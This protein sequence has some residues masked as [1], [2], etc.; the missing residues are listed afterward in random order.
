MIEAYD[1]LVRD[2]LST[3][4]RDIPGRARIVK[5]KIIRNVAAEISLARINLIRNSE[6]LADGPSDDERLSDHN[7]ADSHVRSKDVRGSQGATSDKHAFLKLSL[8]QNQRSEKIDRA[9]HYGHDALAANDVVSVLQQ[10]RDKGGP[11][12]AGLHSL[13]TIKDQGAVPTKVV[14]ILS[15]WSPGSDP[16]TYD[17]QRVMQ[18]QENEKSRVGNK[19]TTYRRGTRNRISRSQD[20]SMFIP[21]SLAVPV[22]RQWGSQPQEE[23]PKAKLQSS[24]V[25]EEDLPMT[26]VERGVF[27]GREAGKKSLLKA[28]KKKRAAGF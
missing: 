16:T 26:Q 15:H 7:E 23:L 4:P 9:P 13:T 27:G 11:V 28:R 12:Y 17:W 5:E 21:S 1:D 25:A 19:S 20:A 14:N 3:L 8:P 24:Q 18:V 2:W 22:V 10:H 6:N